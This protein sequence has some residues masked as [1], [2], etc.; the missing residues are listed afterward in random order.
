MNIK[1]VRKSVERML[2]DTHIY[3]FFFVFRVSYM[4]VDLLNM[5][6]ILV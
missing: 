6:L 5:Y 4:Y 3:N 1:N 2:F